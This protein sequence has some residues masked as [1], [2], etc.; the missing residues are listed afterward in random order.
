MV[1]CLFRT[2]TLLHYFSFDTII[3]RHERGITFASLYHDQIVVPVILGFFLLFCPTET[4]SR[5]LSLISSNA[6]STPNLILR[7][8]E[9]PFRA[10][11]NINSCFFVTHF[12]SI[13]ILSYTSFLSL[14]IGLVDEEL[15]VEFP[16][17]SSLI[18]SGFDRIESFI[19]R[20]S[21]GIG[22]S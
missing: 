4:V 22:Q 17:L 13:E 20:L 18:L 12:F 15:H 16:S 7:H 10:N 8:Y 6:S 11:G 1:I 19:S 5:I 14:H 21:Y 3:L 9:Y 2:I